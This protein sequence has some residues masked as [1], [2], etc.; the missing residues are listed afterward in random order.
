MFNSVRM[1]CTS[2]KDFARLKLNLSWSDD[3][4]STQP[5]KHRRLQPCIHKRHSKQT[6]EQAS[7][8]RTTRSENTESNDSHIRSHHIVWFSYVV[9]AYRR[10]SR[11]KSNTLYFYIWTE[12]KTNRIELCPYGW[13][14]YTQ[15]RK[16][17]KY[18]CRCCPLQLSFALL[19]TV[20]YLISTG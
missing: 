6:N 4:N 3:N 12:N 10:F 1:I 17:K 14:C 13:Y 8:Q 5:Y 19:F 9:R 7:K 11:L 15:Y 16:T 20:K 2:A 18:K